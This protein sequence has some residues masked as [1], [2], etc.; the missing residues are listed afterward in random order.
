MTSSPITQY[1]VHIS[2]TVS[3]VAR[4]GARY[5]A[6]REGTVDRCERGYAVRCAAAAGSTEFWADPDAATDA[7]IEMLRV[8]ALKGIS[9]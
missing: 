7:A 6:V 5:T 9:R 1:P 2:V 3:T 4:N 8:E